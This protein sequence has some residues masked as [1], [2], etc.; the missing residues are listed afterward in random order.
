[1]QLKTRGDPDFQQE[2]NNKENFLDHYDF[3]VFDWKLEN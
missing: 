3:L 1:M 2:E